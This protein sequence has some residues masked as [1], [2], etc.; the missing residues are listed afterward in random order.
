MEYEWDFL[1]HTWSGRAISA[2]GGAHVDKQLWVSVLSNTV[3][4]W[5][6]TNAAGKTAPASL[7]WR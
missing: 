3:S 5:T 4:S 2:A 6:A 1:P 7:F